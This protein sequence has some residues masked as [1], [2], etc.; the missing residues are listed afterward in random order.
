MSRMFIKKIM[1]II[2]ILNIFL[3]SACSIL[4]TY[5]EE[6]YITLKFVMN[7]EGNKLITITLDSSNKT[8]LIEP[9]D[10][11]GI[12]NDFK[13]QVIKGKYTK[14]KNDWNLES[15]GKIYT[16]KK[17]IMGLYEMQYE[18]CLYIGAAFTPM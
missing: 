11:N 6:E 5:N 10:R 3:M 17:S 12:D 14:H 15:N 9:K 7:C 13:K 18:D 8:Y 1:A 16:I 4:L 2:F